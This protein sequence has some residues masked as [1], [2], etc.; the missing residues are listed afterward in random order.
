MGQGTH[1]SLY[2]RWGQGPEFEGYA[3]AAQPPQRKFRLL[4]CEAAGRVSI[5]VSARY[6][7]APLV[8]RDASTTAYTLVIAEGKGML[9]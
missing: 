2:S 7:N 5:M 9:R 4:P 1:T 8:R 6:L 3:N